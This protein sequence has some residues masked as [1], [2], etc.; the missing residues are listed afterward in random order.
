MCQTAPLCLDQHPNYIRV[1]GKPAFAI[2]RIGLIAA[3]GALKPM[4]TLWRQLA[5]EAGLR[6]LH[7]VG[8]I[9]GHEPR[10]QAA[11]SLWGQGV[12]A[13]F[14]FVPSLSW[15]F[16]SSSLDEGKVATTTNLPVGVDVQYWGASA[17]FDRRPR[18]PDWHSNW[19]RQTYPASEPVGI[20]RADESAAKDLAITP[21]QFGDG[22]GA[23][24]RAMSK[25][26]QQPGARGRLPTLSLTP[27]A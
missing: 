12:D 26:P 8:T 7:I 6:G 24:F 13:G 3:E 27:S 23:S 25:Q 17:G 20:C 18:I 10:E 21:Q 15:A 22:L 9:G 2:Y 19:R 16:D 11:T 1:D 14:H 5:V 4:L